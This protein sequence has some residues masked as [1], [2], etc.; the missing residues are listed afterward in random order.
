MKV[1]ISSV[2]R[3]LEEERDA[4]PGLIQATGNEP[5]RFEDYTAMNV[6][7]RQACLD[8]VED[9]DVYLLLLGEHYGSPLADTGKAPTEEEFVVARRRGIPILAFRKLN[10]QPDAEQTEFIARVEN[11]A[12]GKFRGSFT[13]TPE[14]LAGVVQALRDVQSAPAALEWISLERPLEPE[15][16]WK[17]DRTWGY[18]SGGGTILEVHLLPV[19]QTSRL[20]VREIETLGRAVASLGR[21]LDLFAMG[22][23][24]AMDVTGDEVVV[25]LPGNPYGERGIRVARGRAV[26]VWETLPRDS[27]G[28][29]ID[30]RDLEQRIERLVKIASETR[31][32]SA[33]T[34][35]GLS[36]APV[37][38]TQEGRIEDLGR[39][40][41]ASVGMS[42]SEPARVEPEDAVPSA[43]LIPGAK[44]IASEL[45]ARLMHAY[46]R[47]RT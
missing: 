44:E 43:A 24:L 5:R 12:Q 21:E 16:V 32:P 31:V 34:A 35:F 33:N 26:T 13:N 45:A 2:R 28:T 7:S 46:R 9:A 19:A 38:F 6:P 40:N 36:L 37:D 29:L 4:L 15:W 23:A 11:Y 27:M 1:F 18:V 30:P 25:Q 8:G 20:S 14:L 41:S 42:S 22:D 17:S 39:R 3:G 47:V 10:V